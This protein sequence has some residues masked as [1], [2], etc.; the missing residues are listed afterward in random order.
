MP[1]YVYQCRECGIQFE[2]VQHF[3]EA[4]VKICPECNGTVQRV[5]CPVGVIFKG[6]GWYVKD[7]AKA[8]SSTLPARDP[9]AKEPANGDKAHKE[10]EHG[11][12]SGAKEPAK[13]AAKPEP[14]AAD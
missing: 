13:P 1:T 14:R 8:K 6:S 3:S 11:D 5:I 2:R 9:D 7:S 12:A 10:A 4:P